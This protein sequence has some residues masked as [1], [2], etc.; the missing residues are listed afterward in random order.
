ME[1]IDKRLLEPNGKPEIREDFN[2]VLD[3]LD[4]MEEGPGPAGPPGIGIQSISGS[5]DSSNKLTLTFTMTDESV[6][7]VEGQITPPAG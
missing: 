1:T 2:R 5:I 6:Q 7:T 3:L 4:G